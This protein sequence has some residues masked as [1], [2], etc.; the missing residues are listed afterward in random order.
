MQA[1]SENMSGRP[2]QKIRLRLSYN[3]QCS[4]ILAEW[5]REKD[6]VCHVR[7][8]YIKIRLHSFIIGNDISLNIRT[9]VRMRTIS[10]T[11]TERSLPSRP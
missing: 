11:Q 6:I 1:K 5:H 10:D 9:H 8:T 4:G 3:C 7:T 2:D